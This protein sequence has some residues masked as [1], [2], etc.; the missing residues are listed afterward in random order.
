MNSQN[1][2]NKLLTSGQLN[3]EEQ[4]SSPIDE[5]LQNL[6]DPS[7]NRIDLFQDSKDDQ[8]ATKITIYEKIK[9]K[10]VS[11]KKCEC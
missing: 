6:E 5:E 11:P 10:E 9:S 7:N 8:V 2:L 4:I 1:N 3:P